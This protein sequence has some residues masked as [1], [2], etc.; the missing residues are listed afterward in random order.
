[1]MRRCVRTLAVGTSSCN[2][3]SRFGASSAPIRVT[4]VTLPPGRFRLATRPSC[5]GS[6]DVE[7][8]IGIVLVAVFAA[9]SEGSAK[10]VTDPWNLAI[11]AY[12]NKYWDAITFHDYPTGTGTF[13]EWMA[14]ECANLA[15]MGPVPA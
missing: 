5:T 7:N 15:A 14:E 3:S 9:G 13:A 2:I 12:T 10:A 11:A 1:M 6:L 4:P 8:T